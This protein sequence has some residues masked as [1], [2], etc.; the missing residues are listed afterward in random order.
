[1]GAAKGGSGLLDLPLWLHHSTNQTRLLK[2][3]RGHPHVPNLERS[4]IM[5]VQPKAVWNP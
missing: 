3:T 2:G 4:F 1:M 5:L